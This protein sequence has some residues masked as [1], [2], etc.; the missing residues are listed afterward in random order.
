[1][2]LFENSRE[3]NTA[4]TITMVEDVLIALGHFVND[5]RV[6]QEGALRAWRVTKGSAQVSIQLLERADYPH[7]RV[8]SAVMTTRPDLAPEV[9]ASLHA[10]LLARNVDL[11]GVAFAVRGDQVL[12]VSERS[13]LDLDRSE[14]VELVRRVQDQA[15][16]VDDELVERYGGTLGGEP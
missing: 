4:S 1:M 8:A 12:L 5:C 7:L 15:D 11:A 10:D 9:R 16:L 3:T 14:V 6:D 2:S 13:T